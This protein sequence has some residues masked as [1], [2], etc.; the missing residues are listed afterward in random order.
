MRAKERERARRL[1]HKGWSVRTIANKIKCS[2]SS[3]SKWVR[4]IPLTSEQ[5][6]NLKLNQDKGR[7]KAANHPNSSRFR[8][9]KIRQQTID[10]AK[11]EI[12]QKCSLENLKLIGSA[13][14]WAEGYMASR[15]SFVFANSDADMIRLMTRFLIKVCRIPLSRLRGKINIHPH[16]DIAQAQIHWTKISGI[17]L[18]QFYKPL[19]AISRAS[20]QKRKTLPFGTFRIIISDVTLCSRIKGWI[21]G[22][23]NWALSSVG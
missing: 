19:L 9:A 10:I 17:P 4:D 11:E 3:I 21:E 18:R 8:W 14:Y 7:A 12:P 1:R 22:L 2:K 13:L 5:I 6:K 16:L 20:K 23:K 15:N